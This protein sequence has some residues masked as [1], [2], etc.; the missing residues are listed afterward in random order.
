[1][2]RDPLDKTRTDLRRRAPYNTTDEDMRRQ[3]PNDMATLAAPMS[4]TVAAAPRGMFGT[5]EQRMS[6]P[7]RTGAFNP[8]LG[9]TPANAR[10]AETKGRPLS[11][12]VGGARRAVGAAM[13]AGRD[14]SRTV[15]ERYRTPGEDMVGPGVDREIDGA[16]QAQRLVAAGGPGARVVYK[17]KDAQGNSVYSD[18]AFDGAEA[19]V[20]GALGTR[21][22]R[23]FN[24]MQ[25]T[26]ADQYA[27]APVLSARQ[28]LDDLQRQQG[29]FDNMAPQV[30]AR[31]NAALS[32]LMQQQLGAQTA[33]TA[34]EAMRNEAQA[35]N[36]GQ[37]ARAAA[38]TA[39]LAED[40]LPREQVR[41]NDAQ[42]DVDRTFGM[43]LVNSRVEA[44]GENAESVARSR[45][46]SNARDM[47]ILEAF[48]QLANEMPEDDQRLSNSALFREAAR[49]RSDLLRRVNNDQ[50][51]LG[52]N[53][54]NPIAGVEGWLTGQN[55]AG[56]LNRRD[57]LAP[58]LLTGDEYTIDKTRGGDIAGRAPTL[59]VGD[60]AT[61]F[62]TDVPAQRMLLES[63]NNARR[64]RQQE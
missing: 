13:D 5:T 36:V 14:L 7:P 59:V 30:A 38:V 24:R 52:W 56:P 27:G 40:D 55:R 33:K 11:D 29:A 58:G 17:G 62:D 31:E 39:T 54:I 60:R 20:R 21:A 41:R 61:R 1:M 37:Q 49:V 6:L 64:F 16:A 46:F 9:T 15:R 57:E 35:A 22:D 63:L 32:Q 48:N 51:R 23:G 19:Q 42:A 43:D 44:L 12:L 10:P 53:I 8:V 2:S 26:L 28:T 34:S 4:Q 45:G 25:A 50:G 18:T 47:A 3:L